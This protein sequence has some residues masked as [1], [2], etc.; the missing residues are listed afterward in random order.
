MWR[1]AVKGH[2]VHRV[3]RITAGKDRT[4]FG[5]LEGFEGGSSVTETFDRVTE[6]L[7]ND[8]ASSK[9][10]LAHHHDIDGPGVVLRFGPQTIFQLFISVASAGVNTEGKE[11]ASVQNN[12][13]RTSI[14]N[15]KPETRIRNPKQFSSNSLHACLTAKYGWCSERTRKT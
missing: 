11:V 8:G 15:R 6:R 10:T 4:E 5:G 12:A 3:H 9:A 2:A 1:H 13:A 7:K 14:S